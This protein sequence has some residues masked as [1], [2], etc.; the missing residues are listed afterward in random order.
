[1]KKVVVFLSMFLLPVGCLYLLW[2]NLT[3]TNRAVS[4][5]PFQ[6]KWGY[7]DRSGKIMIEPQYKMIGRFSEGLARVF[8]NDDFGY[9]DKSATVV[10]KPQ[11]DQTWHFSD[12]LAAVAYRGE[13][14]FIDPTGGFAIKPQFFENGTTTISV[15]FTITAP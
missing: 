7:I 9:I 4:T 1:M 10:I 2:A 8:L 12:G 13:W 14:G 6:G 3:D 15:T 5:D 11:F